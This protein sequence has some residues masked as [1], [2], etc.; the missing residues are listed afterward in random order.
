MWKYV[1]KTKPR[2]G[3]EVYSIRSD[4]ISKL[5]LNLSIVFYN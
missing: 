4:P 3:C 2:V 5:L 1:C